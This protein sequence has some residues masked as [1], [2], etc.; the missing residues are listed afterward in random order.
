MLADHFFVADGLVTPD[1]VRSR[2]T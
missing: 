1:Q 2:S